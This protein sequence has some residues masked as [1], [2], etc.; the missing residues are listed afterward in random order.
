MEVKPDVMEI[1]GKYKKHLETGVDISEEKMEANEYKP[2]ITKED[3]CSLVRL[4][5]VT[6]IERMWD[7]ISYPNRLVEGEAGCRLSNKFIC[8]RVIEC[9]VV[10]IPGDGYR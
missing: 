7:E 5:P 9:T 10:V 3:I 8:R 4:V 1:P 6:K 2:M